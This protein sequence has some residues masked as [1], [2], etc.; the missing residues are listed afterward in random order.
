MRNI[1]AQPAKP[2]GAAK[3]LARLFMPTTLPPTPSWEQVAATG[4]PD[5]PSPGIAHD[6]LEPGPAGM[7][8]RRPEAVEKSG[9]PEVARKRANKAPSDAAEHVD[10]RGG[11]GGRGIDG[12]MRSCGSPLAAATSSGALA[13]PQSMRLG[14]HIMSRPRSAPDE[15]VQ[16]SGQS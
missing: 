4:L 1:T 14:E 7:L 8:S 13:L 2:R 16:A 6:A 15:R 11:C 5:H 10:Q 3:T 9:P 12:R